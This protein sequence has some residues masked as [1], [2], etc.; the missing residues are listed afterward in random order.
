MRRCSEFGTESALG[1]ATPNEVP[2]TNSRKEARNRQSARD[3]SG[4]KLAAE[5]GGGGTHRSGRVQRKLRQARGLRR[6]RRRRC[7]VH[8]PDRRAHRHGGGGGGRVR[9]SGRRARGHLS[10]CRV[11][12]F[13][14]HESRGRPQSIKTVHSP[15]L[16]NLHEAPPTSPH[17][18]P[19]A[20]KTQRA[21][22]MLIIVQIVAISWLQFFF[23]LS[24]SHLYI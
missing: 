19:L 13:R 3:L 9:E 20:S 16:R 22:V 15:E 12:K 10:P 8:P 11:G 7:G 6:R 2:P 21:H 14:E 4:K 1:F 5:S 18:V 24:I 23:S 17:S